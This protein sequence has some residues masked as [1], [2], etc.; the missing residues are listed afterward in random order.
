LSR[1]GAPLPHASTGAGEE[2][3][4]A[5][6]P[7]RW[8]L[9]VAG[10][11]AVGLAALG[12]ILPILPTTPFVL[13]AAACFARSS[14]R[15]HDW[16]LATRVFGP[17]IEDW[18]T[19]RGLSRR[20]KISSVTMMALVGGASVLF[21]VEPLWLDLSIAVVLITVASWLVSRPTA[22]DRRLED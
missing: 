16:L 15:F 11:V 13:V 4:L 21:F 17:L 10:F 5:R 14:P 2:R 7:L 12:V 6:G 22:P 8:A 3:G 1:R 18:R 9:F 19:H 20:A